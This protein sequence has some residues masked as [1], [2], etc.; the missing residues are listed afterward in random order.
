M[1]IA[2]LTFTACD[3]Y[4]QRLQNYALQELLKE[5]GNDVRTILQSEYSITLKR[6]VKQ[7]IKLV[8]GKEKKFNKI[9]RNIK[10]YFFDKKYIR[11]SN[12]HNTF[13]E[14]KNATEY[15]RFISGSDQVWAP[16]E[17]RLKMYM[18]YGIPK[19]KKYSYAASIA[20]YEIP[21]ELKKKYK[22]YLESFSLISVR[23]NQSKVLLDN[24]LDKNE[25]RVDLDPT[26][27]LN[28]SEWQK[29]E[30]KPK[31]FE[32]NKYILVYNLGSVTPQKIEDYAY[33]HNYKII[34]IMDENSK[35]YLSDPGEFIYLIH[36]AEIIYTDSYHGTVFSIIFE[37]K[38]VHSV[39]NIR[40]NNMNSRFDTLF[41][42]L[43][44]DVNN[45][46]NIDNICINYNDINI[47]LETERKKSLKTIR[48]LA[49]KV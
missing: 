12:M 47:K 4:G 7:F 36:N 43:G 17:G 20:S 35:A 18:Q 34:S 46:S 8:I 2:I 11:Y 6:L 24:I 26:L 21:N 23:E 22:E 13:Y 45:I 28:K 30:K 32:K 37:K 40:K 1:K 38:F 5:N 29:I 15:D 9:K 14:L 42:I 44:I 31:W 16:V 10:F 49:N 25:V 27:L 41:G 48:I 3:N 33:N 19:E 39:R